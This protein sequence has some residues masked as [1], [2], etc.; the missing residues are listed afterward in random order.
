MLRGGVRPGH[1]LEAAAG[2]AGPAAAAAAGRRGRPATAGRRLRGRSLR[3]LPAGRDEELVGLGR[4]GRGG[5]RAA[6]AL[7]EGAGVKSVAPRSPSRC[8]RS[9]CADLSGIS[10]SVPV[11]TAPGR[12]LGMG[13]ESRRLRRHG[14][15][16]QGGRGAR[17]G[18]R[19]GQDTV[20]LLLQQSASL[21]LAAQRLLGHHEEKVSVGQSL[22]VEQPAGATEGRGVDVRPA[23]P[24]RPRPAAA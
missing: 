20:S 24:S 18:E 22:R 5:P 1:G 9:R 17:G 12:P 19:R 3:Y 14:G 15:G 6:P 21:T 8:S 2:E 7:G 13:G 23:P 16:A 4:W 11:R 10:V